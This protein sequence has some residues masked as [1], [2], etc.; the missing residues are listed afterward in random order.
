LTTQAGTILGP[1]LFDVSL[2]TRYQRATRWLNH[3]DS[4]FTSLFG[5]QA[6]SLL[7]YL[8]GPDADPS[9]RAA[10]TATLQ[11]LEANTRFAD[12]FP[13]HAGYSLDTLLANWREW[14][15]SQ[16]LGQSGQPGQ[17]PPHHRETL[18]QELIPLVRDSQSLPKDRLLAIR[19]LRSGGYLLGADALIALL[20]PTTE[21]L[22]REA[23]L[24]ALRSITGLAHD[25]AEAWQSWW[26]SVDSS[27]SI[28]NTT[29]ISLE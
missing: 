6:A 4:A 10:F 18:E 9:R 3:D 20:D 24:A 23:A 27:C 16:P 12:V 11:S 28:G 13:R 5:A 8:A 22:L 25:D 14:L 17:P 26:R 2:E 15:E 21:P 19:A 7:E 29:L 1:E